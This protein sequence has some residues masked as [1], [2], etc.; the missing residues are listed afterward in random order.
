[1]DDLGGVKRRAA[2]MQAWPVRGKLVVGEAAN[3]RH[4]RVLGCHRDDFP[5]LTGLSRFQKCLDRGGRAPSVLEP[6]STAR[7]RAEWSGRSA[8]TESISGPPVSVTVRTRSPAVF[9]SSCACRQSHPR[10]ATRRYSLIVPPARVC[11]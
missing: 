7:G 10:H 8:L 3:D 6:T 11:L 9:S 4:V 2:A 1:M 5:A